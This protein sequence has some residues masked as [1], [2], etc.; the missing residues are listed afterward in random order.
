M[1][2]KSEQTIELQGLSSQTLGILLDCIYSEK[3][4]FTIENVQEILP[5][6]T[7]LQL[8]DI[9]NGCE[10]FLRAQ[11]DPHN[12]L[13]IRKFAEIHDC[14]NLKG[15]TQEFIFENFTHIVQ[16]SEEF[17]HLSATELEELIR[18]NEIEVANEQTVY[19]CVFK[20]IG[21]IRQSTSLNYS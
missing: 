3:F 7:L 8:D 6:A 20:W 11:L 15:S 12:C 16:N 17:L 13:G 18:S 21:M 2:E 14:I 1:K 5:A 4:M 10:D 19:N 9:R